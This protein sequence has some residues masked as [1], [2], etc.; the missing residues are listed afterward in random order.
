MSDIKI[1]V[2]AAVDASVQKAFDDVGKAS[3][4]AAKQAAGSWEKLERE[5]EREANRILRDRER[6]E[7]AAQ[8]AIEQTAA[9]QKRAVKTAADN[10]VRTEERTARE[11]ERLERYKLQIRIRSS[12]MAG[13][14]AAQEA[15][16]ETRERARQAKLEEREEERA[17][18]RR[19]AFF[20][21]RIGIGRRAS[22]GVSG[23]AAMLY[24]YGGALLSG[25]FR[26][27]GVETDPSRL[28]QQGIENRAVAQQVV[29]A[30]PSMIGAS[31]EQRQ[32]MAGAL[33]TQAQHVANETA[34]DTG[35]VLASA[36]RFV[37]LTGDFETARATLGDIA[38]LSR[39]TGSSL[40][41]MSASAAEVANHLGN[42]QD[43]A[44][45]T[46][47]VM[48]AIAGQGKLGAVEIRD[49]ALQMA[50]LASQAPK[51]EGDTTKTI[52]ILGA[53]AQ[54]SKLRGGSAN[55]TQAATAVMRLSQDLLKPT[56]VKAWAAVGQSPFTD[57]THTKLRTPEEIILTALKASGGDLVKLAKLFPNQMSMRAVTGFASI[58]QEAGGGKKGAEAVADEFTRLTS[59]M[60][61]QEEVEREF[62]AQMHTAQSRIQIFNNHMQQTAQQ[63]AEALLPAVDALAPKIVAFAA[64]ISH[65]LSVMT[66]SGSD[67]VNARARE[68]EGQE[69]KTEALLKG[70]IKTE[71]GKGGKTVTV[72]SGQAV[73]LL[74]NQGAARAKLH[75]DIEGQIDTAKET[76]DKA[77][78][79]AYSDKVYSWNPIRKLI[80]WGKSEL[81]FESSDKALQ[82]AQQQFDELKRHNAEVIDES[83]RSNALLRDIFRAVKDG[84][85]RIDEPLPAADH[86][87]REP[88]A[89]HE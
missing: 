34:S 47:A 44:G 58:Y 25:M 52:A 56:T 15:A 85:A 66:G 71:T 67:E 81:G 80:N 13:R 46:M 64:G 48:R 30:A 2:G 75:G 16:R 65:W 70:S 18:S 43:K 33:L 42:V 14:Y 8:K 50:K 21:G 77:K 12:E 31:V 72:Y 36:Q 57:K 11:V 9:A 62:T 63:L 53:M 55:A 83:K 19:R 3:T 82:K 4:R 20:G 28:V 26:G 29:N 51:F 41:D 59:A 60:L 32:G 27:L 78:A 86:T 61:T 6:A 40:E 10:E 5:L 74:K 17:R 23:G 39:A 38:V 76:L 87:A 88:A 35:D 24:G 84:N 37:A 79:A 1:R 68:V 49:M 45:M 22:I 7:R 54:E 73:D 69:G 89:S